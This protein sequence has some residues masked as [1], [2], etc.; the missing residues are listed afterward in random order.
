MSPQTRKNHQ[1]LPFFILLNFAQKFS[2]K[3]EIS[4]KFMKYVFFVISSKILQE[5][6][7]SL[8]GG[9]KKYRNTFSFE[10]ILFKGLHF[11]RMS[12]KIE[13]S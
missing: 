11:S 1:T 13:N 8:N 10:E 9:Q 2:Q 6:L 12:Q 4:G 3:V 7:Q 5:I